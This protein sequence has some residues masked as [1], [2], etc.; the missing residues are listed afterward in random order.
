MISSGLKV[1]EVLLYVSYVLL[2][3]RL[4]LIT[5]RRYL[6]INQ[7]QVSHVLGRKQYLSFE[8]IYSNKF[9]TGII[10]NFENRL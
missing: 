9:D 3:Q 1:S 5:S 4:I 8:E 2:K 6:I 7:M 10:G